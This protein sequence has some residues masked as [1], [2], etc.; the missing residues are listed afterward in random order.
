MLSD[1]FLTD[2]LGKRNVMNVLKKNYYLVIL[3][4][5]SA[6]VFTAC[7][8]DDGTMGP[9]DEITSFNENGF[10]IINEGPESTGN[11]SISFYHRNF[12]LVANN[13]FQE[14]NN[15]ETIGNGVQH[16]NIIDGK[17]Y[18][19]ARNSNKIVI[20]NPEDMKKLGEI[21]GFQQPQFIIK[22]AEGK[23]Y[24]SQWGADGTNGS[25]QIVD[26]NNNSITGSIMTRPGPQEMVRAG[27]NVFLAN[28]GGVYVDS[29]VTKI[30]VP[31]DEVLKTI[32]VGLSPTYLEL[33]KDLNLWVLTRGLIN[34]PGNPDEN[35]KGRLVKI[36]NDEV[37]L[38]LKVKPSA[39][40]LTINQTKDKIYFVQNGWVYEHGIFDTS[41]S[42]VPFIERFFY[43]LEVDSK[44][45]NFVGFDAKDLVLNGEMYIID[46]D[47]MAIDTVDVGSTPG[48]AFFQ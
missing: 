3:L 44:T 34:N 36:E 31:N 39:N 10:F 40:G 46:E 5:I 22:A 38:S 15:G 7:P 33:D 48:R 16:M 14:S 25:I 8:D 1:P 13:I 18:I 19:V 45:N 32:N 6:L 11:G 47:R 30:S 4:G 2:S 21:T 17:A 12:K 43:G 27:N 42:L 9:V 24:V 41:I 23:A 20:A 37:I 29:I 35:I 28:S 26:L